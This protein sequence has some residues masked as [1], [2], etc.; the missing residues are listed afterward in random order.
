MLDFYDAYWLPFGGCLTELERRG[1][2]VDTEHLRHVQRK[3]E[4]DLHR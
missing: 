1:F 2:H 4:D 3:A